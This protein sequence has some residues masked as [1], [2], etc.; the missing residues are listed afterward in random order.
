MRVGVDATS[1]TNRRGF[2][3]FTRNV[4]TQLVAR[5]DGTVYVMYVDS[6]T[7][8]RADLP[9]AAETR[10]VE[11]G[12]APSVA[13][14]ATSRRRMGDILR[15]TRAVRGDELDAFLFPSVYTYFPVLGIPTV[16][17]VHDAMTS[18]LPDLTLPS[19]RARVLWR[20]KE[21]TALRLASRVFT[22]SET[23]RTAISERFGLERSS[24]AVVPEAPDPVFR[25]ADERAV[26][27]AQA[28]VGLSPGEPFLLYAGGISP[29]KDVTTLLEAYSRLGPPRPRLL[30]VGELETEVYASDAAAVRGLIARLGIDD[31]V[32]LP[33]FV[34]D[35]TLAALYS[36]ALAVALPSLAE[37]FGLPPVEAAACGAPTLLSDI[38]AHRETLGSAAI[39]FPPRDADRLAEELRRVIDDPDH[40]LAVGRR[41]RA[42]VEHLSWDAAADRLQA[43]IR[44]AA[45]G[46]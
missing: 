6:A 21:Q 10:L 9:A 37:G 35:E 29:H 5:D 25:P 22:V 27:R 44:D 36:G 45:E 46:A 13:A 32:L 43:V 17:G 38:P 33:G 7:A 28:V 12:E 30:V 14:S 19:R 15:M 2:G 20:A 42:A 4:V 16:V 26:E 41:C 8:S 11:V 1:W 31:S 40:R 24:L 18:E 3:R 34:P 23:S 39:F